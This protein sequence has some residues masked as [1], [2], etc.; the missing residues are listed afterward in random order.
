MDF[1]YLFAYIDLKKLIIKKS[2]VFKVKKIDAFEQKI[3]KRPALTTI[4]KKKL[5][6]K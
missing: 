6:S 4:S 3:C 2:I 5:L 1:K